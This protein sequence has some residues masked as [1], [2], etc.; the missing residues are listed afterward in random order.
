[1][2][3]RDRYEKIERVPGSPKAGYEYRLGPATRGM[4]D[5]RM[6][7]TVRPTFGSQEANWDIGV[8]GP[9]S[10]TVQ[11]IR[12]LDKALR[13]GIYLYDELD[14]EVEAEN[15]RR[16]QQMR[17]DHA[18]WEA[19]RE[20]ERPAR[21]AAARARE[22]RLQST[23][24]ED[25][26][27]CPECGHVDDA[28]AFEEVVY[29]CSRCSSRKR[30]TDDGNRCDTDNIFMAKVG[31]LSCPECEEPIDELPTVPAKRIDNEWVEVE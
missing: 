2:S 14:P 26:A 15:E 13:V 24:V 19:Q 6:T 4:S 20:A 23:P 22:K 28:E 18:R 3:W 7:V 8:H 30:G 29:E 11:N 1:M 16:D 9:G 31:D 5:R 27:K 12:D 25:A 21:E 10:F 17:E